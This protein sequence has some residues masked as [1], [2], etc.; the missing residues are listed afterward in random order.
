MADS[1]TGPWRW[2]THIQ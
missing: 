1:L 2:Q